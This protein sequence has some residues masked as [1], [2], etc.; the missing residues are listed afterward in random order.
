MG[1]EGPE[2][3]QAAKSEGFG[4]FPN[5]S[6]ALQASMARKWSSSEATFAR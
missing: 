2:A 6:L 4:V 1:D 5:P 3:R